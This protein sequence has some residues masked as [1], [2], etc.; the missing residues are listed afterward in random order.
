[1]V[2]DFQANQCKTN[3]PPMFDIDNRRIFYYT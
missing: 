2:I 3:P 1:L